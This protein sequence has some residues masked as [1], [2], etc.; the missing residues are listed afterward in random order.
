[1]SDYKPK[2][3]DRVRV[4]REGVV[5]ETFN[6]G[7]TVDV[8]GLR[9]DITYGHTFE[10]LTPPEPDRNSIV[11]DR[12]NDVWRHAGGKKWVEMNSGASASWDRLIA[13]YGPVKVYGEIS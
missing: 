12:E 8:D 1:M 11:I 4:S 10:L 13:G 3:G 9:Y 7:E 2:N 6:N 5:V